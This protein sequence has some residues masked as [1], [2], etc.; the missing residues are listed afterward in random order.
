MSRRSW[1]ASRAASCFGIEGN[2]RVALTVAQSRYSWRVLSLGGGAHV[3]DRSQQSSSRLR[4][5]P[6]T[7]PPDSEGR[8]PVG[9]TSHSWNSR[10]P[11]ASTA[12]RPSACWQAVLVQRLFAIVTVVA[13]MLL[14]GCGSDAHSAGLSRSQIT[15]GLQGSPPR[16]AFLHA[17]ANRLIS[18]GPRRSMPFC[19]AFAAIQSYYADASVMP[20]RA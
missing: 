20:T 8:A 17:K 9:T 3:P 19:S 18:G 14:T 4:R 11:S 16:L 15:A 1:S 12:C 7:V 13:A 2:R 6:R 5:W 10:T